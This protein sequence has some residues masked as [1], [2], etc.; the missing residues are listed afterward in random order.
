MK[1][2]D[3]RSA[4][5]RWPEDRRR[6]RHR[7]DDRTDKQPPPSARSRPPARRG[8]RLAGRSCDS[9][10]ERL[11]LDLDDD[12]PTLVRDASL[13]GPR[14][15][16]RLATDWW[17]R[18]RSLSALPDPDR[19]EPE[20]REGGRRHREHRRHRA[21]PLR[22]R[23][24]RRAG[25]APRSPRRRRAGDARRARADVSEAVAASRP[26]VGEIAQ[27][28]QAFIARHLVG[29]GGMRSGERLLLGGD[30]GGERIGL[31]FQRSDARTGRGQL[32][33]SPR[34]APAPGRPRSTDRRWSSIARSR[35]AT[36][37]RP[38]ARCGTAHLVVRLHDGLG[39]LGDDRLGGSHRVGFHAR[40][41]RVDQ[42]LRLRQQ[43][44]RDRLRVLRD[45]KPAPSR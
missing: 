9:D 23:S 31:G 20:D 8:S 28:D 34:S 44:P 29:D 42:R 11:Q 38:S 7:Q 12:R 19:D 43:L 33:W 1:L 6:R 24:I 30:L 22:L 5:W 13:A 26:C 10:R 15:R 2:A 25:S 3:E 17:G 32:G 35:S 45:G 37:R 16:A 27:D 36:G 21:Q 4:A 39:R 18:A 40:V 14:D 41:H